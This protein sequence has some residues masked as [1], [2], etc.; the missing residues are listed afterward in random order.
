M[1]RLGYCQGLAFKGV[2]TASYRLM[3]CKN[4]GFKRQP[5]LPNLVE[6]LVPRCRSLLDRGLIS[7]TAPCS[8]IFGMTCWMRMTG[9]Q[10]VIGCANRRNVRTILAE[11]SAVHLL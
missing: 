3:L 1:A 7:F 2:R 4:L 9:L 11:R 8:T 10:T 6:L 5:S